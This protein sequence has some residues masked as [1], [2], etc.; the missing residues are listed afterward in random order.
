MNARISCDLRFKRCMH[1]KCL[2]GSGDPYYQPPGSEC[3]TPVA[4]CKLVANGYY[5]AVRRRGEKTGCDCCASVD[6]QL[7]H[8]VPQTWPPPPPRP[9][10][11]PPS[12]LPYLPYFHY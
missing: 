8:L 3:P 2:N 6:M 9:P 10:A 7:C 4:L 12:R 5:Y 1:S 11:L